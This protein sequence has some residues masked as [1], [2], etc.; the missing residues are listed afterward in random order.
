MYPST[1]KLKKLY[2]T[3]YAQTQTL[4]QVLRPSKDNYFKKD[5][6]WG[7]S[8]LAHIYNGLIPSLI[9]CSLIFTIYLIYLG[10]FPC[11]LL[12]LLLYSI[13]TS[14]PKFNSHF[15]TP[16]ISIPDPLIVCK[17]V[18]VQEN[19]WHHLSWDRTQRRD[20]NCLMSEL[21]VSGSLDGPRPFCSHTF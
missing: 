4:V 14:K 15:I 7:G 11:A 2:S 9:I 17:S 3:V 18:F 1:A 6:S 21:R 16:E 5:S 19:M 12:C 10:P 13:C 8:R 20:K